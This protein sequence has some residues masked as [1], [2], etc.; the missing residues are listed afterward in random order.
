VSYLGHVITEKGVLPDPRKVLTIE[1]YPR[2]T[3]VKQLKSYLGIASYYRKF[4]PNFSRIAAPLHALLKA[5]MSFEWKEEQEL[6]FQTLKDKLVSK[7]I[8]QYPDFAKE[9]VLTTDA[10]NDGLGAILSQ[11]EIG[12]DLPIAYASR[13]LN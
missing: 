11:G 5:N 8:L 12:K 7:P 1:N 6:A 13:N 2:P 9:F 3:N 10:S 4:I